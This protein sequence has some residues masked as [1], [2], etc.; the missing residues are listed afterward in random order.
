MIQTRTQYLELFKSVSEAIEFE[1]ACLAIGVH[2]PVCADLVVLGVEPTSE[3]WT[4][5][6]EALEVSEREHEERASDEE[7]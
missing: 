2:R 7:G 6:A 4:W 1:D 3:Y 5:L